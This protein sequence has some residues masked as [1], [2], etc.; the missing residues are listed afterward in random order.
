MRAETD[1]KWSSWRGCSVITV[2]VFCICASAAFD[3]QTN[4]STLQGKVIDSSG[5]PVSKARISIRNLQANTAQALLSERDGRYALRNI[6]PGEYEI[7]VSASGLPAKMLHVTVGE[8]SRTVANVTMPSPVASSA[9][10]PA[11]AGSQ[12][13]R[14]IPLNGRSATDVATLEPGVA[15]T[16]TQSAGG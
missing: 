12:N 3:A 2:L 1:S 6:P 4:G 7:A 13:V 11:K 10:P 15:T 14:D 16:R 5:L 8:N 9:G